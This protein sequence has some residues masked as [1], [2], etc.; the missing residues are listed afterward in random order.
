M[1]QK[2]FLAQLVEQRIENPCVPGSIPGETTNRFFREAVFV[3]IDLRKLLFFKFLHYYLF[4]V[5]GIVLSLSIRKRLQV[6]TPE[7]LIQE[8]KTEVEIMLKNFSV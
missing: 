1:K 6:L 3:F 7:S 2:G 5:L 4:W 8:L